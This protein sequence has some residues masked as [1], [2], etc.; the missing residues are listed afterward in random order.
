MSVNFEELDY[1]QT[2]L[3]ELILRRR[4]ALE[5]G[6]RIVFEVK[7]NEDF[8]MSSLFHEAEVALTDLGLAGLEGEQLDIVVGGL[9]LGY[10]AAAAMK[11]TQVARMIVVEALAPVIDWHQR[12]L[13]PNG[14]LLT[15][16]AR[17]HYYHE[18]FFALAR[19]TG[20][21]PDEP[22]HLFDAILLD[23][24]HTPEALL[25]PS[26]ADFYSEEGLTRLRAFLKPGGVFALWSNDAPEQG[27][28]DLLSRVFD[29]VEGHVVEFDNPI[30][31]NTAENGVYVA[32]VK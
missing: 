10:T 22:G 26:H 29:E 13:V 19:G 3:G 7:L 4:R 23:I 20:F 25:N 18:D 2:D 1:Q 5:M 21:D 17:C 8:L 30:Q 27:F 14:A 24:D 9:G 32:K 16:D 12:D 28:L 15:G 31:G 6:G 11:Y